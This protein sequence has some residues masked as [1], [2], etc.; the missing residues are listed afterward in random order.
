MAAVCSVS[1]ADSE[2]RSTYEISGENRK[3]TEIMHKL[4]N[5]KNLYEQGLLSDQVFKSQKRKL[6]G[7]EEHKSGVGAQLPAHKLLQVASTKPL[8]PVITNSFWW[9]FFII[10]GTM[11]LHLWWKDDYKRDIRVGSLHPRTVHLKVPCK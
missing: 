7:F 11:V 8:G 4:A 3:Q 10:L 2:S 6:V 9:S 1:N 5:L